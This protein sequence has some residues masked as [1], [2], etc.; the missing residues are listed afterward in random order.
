[1]Q[2]PA[3]EARAQLARSRVLL[4]QAGADARGEV[5]ASLDRASEL[6]RSTG[7]RS[8]EPQI[9]VE[10][11]RLAGLLCDAGSREQSLRE[12]HRLFSEMGATGYAERLE[13]G[14]ASGAS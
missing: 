11:A 5:E 9:Q 2:I 10:R 1:M 6:V 7:A 12:A 14:L 8:Y 4:A 13:K 3:A